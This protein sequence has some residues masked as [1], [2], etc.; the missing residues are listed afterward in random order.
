MKID[1]VKKLTSRKFWVAVGTFVT[2]LLIAFG[3]PNITIEQV[4]ALITAAGTMI[5]YIIGEG[6]VD[7][8]RD[9]TT[10]EIKKE[11]ENNT[12]NENIE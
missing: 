9:N 1:W 10:V 3:V 8:S 2:T 11:T 7:A 5:A 12:E 6:L 4:A